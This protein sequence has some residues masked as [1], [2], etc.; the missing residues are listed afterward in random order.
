MKILINESQNYAGK[1]PS[2]GNLHREVKQAIN[3]PGVRTILLREYKI[4]KKEIRAMD[5]S[6][7]R[8]SLL[9]SFFKNSSVPETA[10][11]VL[12]PPKDS[13]ISRKTISV[14]ENQYSNIENVGQAMF[15]SFI[16]KAYKMCELYKETVKG[17]KNHPL[18]KQWRKD[19]TVVEKNVRKALN[20]YSSAYNHKNDDE[21]VS[22]AK[23]FKDFGQE[24]LKIDSR[25][26]ANRLI[27]QKDLANKVNEG[28]DEIAQN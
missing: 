4:G 8:I 16:N 22:L 19:I 5:A 13:L 7:I 24:E 2:F 27:A 26:N 28:W 23:Q 11:L 1:N 6:P 17:A 3:T 18:N 25:H 12:S 14:A 15:A 9:S 20:N 21:M 10:G